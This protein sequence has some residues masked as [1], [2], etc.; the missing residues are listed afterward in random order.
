MIKE[1]T[2]RLWVAIPEFLAKRMPSSPKEVK[3]WVLEAIMQRLECEHNSEK[4]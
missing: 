2:L 4:V 3:A 1:G